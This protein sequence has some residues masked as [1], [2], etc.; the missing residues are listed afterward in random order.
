MAGRRLK[1]TAEVQH[2]ILSFVRAGS[3]DWVAAEAAGISKSTFYRWMR[4]GEQAADGIY[5]DF[6]GEV[7]QAR[8]QARVAA[9]AEVRRDNPLAWLRYG[10]GRQR[11]GE[12]GWTESRELLGQDGGPVRFTLD[13][14]GSRQL[15]AHPQQA[16]LETPKEESSNGQTEATEFIY[17]RRNPLRRARGGDLHPSAL[18]PHRGQHQVRQDLRLP[19]LALRRGH[20]STAPP[21][22]TTGGSHPSSPRPKS[23]TAG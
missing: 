10:P 17:T 12:P 23:P 14:G 4:Q 1:L 15:E 8:A 6:H 9:E 20:R 21:A 22:V 2:Q 18:Q 13:P 11:P 7:R 5:F 16:Q 19:G 3:Y